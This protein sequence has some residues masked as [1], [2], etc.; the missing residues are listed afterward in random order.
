ML[1]IG[2]SSL[3]KREKVIAHSRVYGVGGEDSKEEWEIVVIA[4][5]VRLLMGKIFLTFELQFE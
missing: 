2:E 1:D 4:V 3:I 5:H